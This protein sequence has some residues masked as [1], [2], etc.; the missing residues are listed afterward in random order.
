MFWIRLKCFY[1]ASLFLIIPTT[2]KGGNFLECVYLALTLSCLLFSL[3]S[4]TKHNLRH[5]TPF[6]S[7]IAGKKQKRKQ[8]Q[9]TTIPQQP[10]Q[11]YQKKN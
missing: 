8:N 9:S 1:L 7:A 3:V 10:Q 4:W 6:E 5:T 2:K 11:K